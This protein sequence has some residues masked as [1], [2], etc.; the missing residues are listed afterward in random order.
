VTEPDRVVVVGVGAVG[1]ALAVGLDRAGVDVRVVARGAHLAAIRAD[2]LTL[3]T[4]TGSTTA[5]LAA[6]A[7][8]ADVDLDDR[9]LVVVA[10]KVHQAE[11]VLDA[12]LRAHG[13]DVPVATLHN[14][15]EGERLAL[16]RQRHVLSTLV[17]VPGVHLEPGVVD[18]HS[19]DPLGVLDV[20][21]YPAGTASPGDHDRARSAAT[22]FAAAGFDARAHADVGPLKHAKLLS[23]LANVLQVLCGPDVDLAAPHAAL[24]EEAL[25]VFAAAGRVA[26]EDGLR[27]RFA[28]LEPG[29]VDG[30]ARPGGSTWQSVE[31]GTGDVETLA[32]NGEVTLL[33][34]VHGVATPVNDLVSR[35][36][37]QVA[38][39]ERTA[40]AFSP[41][42]LARGTT[43]R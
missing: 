2:G 25:A 41:D 19:A 13:P 21:P 28:V 15:L 14:G 42:D 30:R 39:G 17:V 24:R 3:R 23:N 32:L 6:H 7:D 4:P 33:G 35:L 43:G 29:E 11:P 10:T 38:A 31:R 26:D 5:R 12:L 40:G 22:L 37:L 20:G 1:G 9:T 8:V 27:A 34:R 18:V 16:R 36:A